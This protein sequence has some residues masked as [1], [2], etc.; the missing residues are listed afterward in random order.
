MESNIYTYTL[1][2]SFHTCTLQQKMTN[3]IS[4]IDSIKAERDRLEKQYVKYEESIVK[5]CDK[6]VKTGDGKSLQKLRKSFPIVKKILHNM[7]KEA[8]EN[9][10]I[11]GLTS[12][13]NILL[14]LNT[15]TKN[16]SIEKVV[17]GNMGI[18]KN[19]LKFLPKDQQ[20]KKTSDALH[21]FLNNSQKKIVKKDII[22]GKVKKDIKKDIV[23]VKEDVKKDIVEVKKDIVEVKKDIV[24][25]KQSVTDRVLEK[26]KQLL[27]GCDTSITYWTFLLESLNKNLNKLFK[28]QGD[29]LAVYLFKI[30][31]IARKCKED[32][33]HDIV[34]NYYVQAKQSKGS[35]GSKKIKLVNIKLSKINYFKQYNNKTLKNVSTMKYVIKDTIKRINETKEN[36]VIAFNYCVAFENNVS[37]KYLESYCDTYGKDELKK[38]VRKI[39]YY[40]I[41]TDNTSMLDCLKEKHKK[42]IKEELEKTF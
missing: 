6:C 2:L 32:Y 34:H 27:K 14:S 12:L 35:K 16:T 40:A 19:I 13:C 15:S 17:S 23:E 29:K 41:N 33:L 1:T 18:V 21:K 26:Q 9:K 22:K 25:V 39:I 24:E 30:C 28:D 10:D 38:L 37:E 3:I 4:T 8:S 7:I 31:V 36:I 5:A 20:K 42:I 11:D